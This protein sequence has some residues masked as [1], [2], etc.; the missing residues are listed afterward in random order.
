MSTG[1]HNFTFGQRSLIP[2]LPVG[3]F[4]AE[5][6]LVTNDI[7]VVSG[8]GPFVGSECGLWSLTALEK[9]NMKDDIINLF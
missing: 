3:M 9:K 5:K 8:L 4:V 2:G 7:K 1:T 6:D